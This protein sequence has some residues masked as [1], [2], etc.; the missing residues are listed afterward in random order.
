[1]NKFRKAALFLFVCLTLI[2]S[3]Q[4]PVTWESAVVMQ[5]ENEGS[6][7]FTAHIA[8]GWHMYGMK[9]I[10]NGPRATSFDFRSIEG[11][12]LVG[13]IT[14]S[15]APKEV[16]DKVF[17]LKIAYW[18]GDVK[19]T[20]KF[21]L[22]DE[23][24]GCTFNG[25][26]WSMA[27][28][29]QSCSTPAKT[30]FDLIYNAEKLPSAET[31]AASDSVQKPLLENV[32]VKT[33]TD[34]ISQAHSQ[35]WEPVDVTS[36]TDVN[37]GWLS[38]FIW[39]FIGG[40]LALLT[41]CVWPM[42]PL[43]VSFFLKRN[44]SRS[45]SIRDALLYGFAIIVIYLAL[46]LIVTLVFGAGKLNELATNAVFNIIFFLILVIFAISFFGAF[47]I[48][49]PSKW[50]NSVDS[51]AE[52]T[53]G[54]ISMF[55]MAFTLVL[56]SFSCTGPLIGTL[57]VEAASQGSIVGPA[58]GMGA[59]ALA[60]A[61]P[62]ALF[63]IFPSLLK[64][65]PKS[66]GWL[67]SV[68]VVLGFLELAL[69]LKFL[70]V[71]DLAYG[72]GILDREVF[73]C[74][75]VVLFA[76]LGMYLLGRIKFSHDAPLN[77]VSIPR[78]FLS[79]FSFSFAIYLIPGLW[80]APLKGV[81]A[82]L[83]PLSTQDF[84]LYETQTGKHFDN[85]DEGM[86]Y[87]AEH[88][89]PVLLDFSGYGCVNCRKMEGAVL[90]TD[91]VKSK[92][93]NDFVF[94]TLM[95]DD[96]TSLSQPVKVEEDGRSMLLETVGEYWGYLQQ[97]KFKASV[98]PYYIIL[99]NAGMPMNESLGFTENPEDFLKWLETGLAKYEEETK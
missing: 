5:S 95:V 13:D 19:F 34:S 33:T 37:A 75:W 54:F 72:W 49:L 43:T 47:N 3:A 55:F 53:T 17:N 18:E 65:M 73:I 71:V 92:I 91:A 66:G 89:M 40:L 30:P 57:L 83:P 74:L 12:T 45:R 39:G 82:F 93:E 24:E 28:N 7:E 36:S 60:L 70:S 14:P 90:D 51:K 26:I 97:H 56:V 76:F 8:D 41:P 23:S 35:W 29:D 52:K 88:N 1:M 9:Q 62:F 80:G 46:G 87:A 4:T 44:S 64:E 99:N 63:A 58:V 20:Q 11:A 38:I 84:N 79:L 21:R 10:E 48:K 98:Q 42:I 78:F 32:G 15:I 69:S 81:S 94:I 85:Y 31:A 2:S 25:V 67:N 68:K 50:S 27:C 59:F 6:I 77:Y 86:A 22:N 61:I 16:M 96:R